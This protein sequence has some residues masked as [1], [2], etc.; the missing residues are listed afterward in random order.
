[1]KTGP[2]CSDYSE[3]EA[4]RVTSCAGSFQNWNHSPQAIS[5]Y[6]RRECKDHRNSAEDDLSSLFVVIRSCLMGLKG[7]VKSVGP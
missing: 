5:F 6:E 4:V 2:E 1:M 3:V 7:S